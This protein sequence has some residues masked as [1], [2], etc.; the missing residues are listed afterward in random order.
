M[1]VA[2]VERGS[3]IE[4]MI[5]LE[6]LIPREEFQLKWTS[7]DGA[8]FNLTITTESSDPIAYLDGLTTADPIVPENLLRD[9]PEGSRVQWFVEATLANGDLAR[10][11]TFISLVR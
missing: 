3:V 6:A 7:I 1:I 8:T 2:S 11:P 9:L 10:S 5:P 4:A